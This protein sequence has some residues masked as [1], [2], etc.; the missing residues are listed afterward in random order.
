MKL[1]GPKTL[2][3]IRVSI[4]G[5]QR[6]DDEASGMMVVVEVDDLAG[7]VPKGC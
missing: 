4:D 1:I 7:Q 6:V 2:P 5:W 3:G